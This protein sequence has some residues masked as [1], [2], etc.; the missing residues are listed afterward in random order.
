M[1]SSGSVYS[2]TLQTITNTKLEELSKKRHEFEEKHHAL[3]SDI[4]HEEDALNRLARLVNGV[5]SCFGIK[6]TPL[7]TNDGGRLGRAIYGGTTNGPLETDLRNIDRFLEQARY[8]PSLS[9]NIVKQWN[10]CLLEHLRVQSLRFQYADLYGK[11]VTEWLST[12]RSKTTSSDQDV[13]MAESF[14]EVPGG[15]KLESRAEWER[16]VFEPALVDVEA[17]NVYLNDLFKTKDPEQKLRL[18]ALQALRSSVKEFEMRLAAT[19]QF[20]V[21]SLRWTI[22]GLL[23]SDLLTDEK[24]AVLRDFEKNNIILAEIADV[25]NMRMA[26]IDTWTWGTEVS[27]EQRRKLNGT[28]NIYMHEDLLQAIFLQYIGVK[29]SV[30]F[31]SALKEF[32]K[33]KA[34][35]KTIRT[36]IPKIDKKRRDYYLG[37]Q[38][39]SPCIQTQR[40]GTHRKNYF[41]FQLLDHENQQVEI[42]DGE[43]EAEFEDFIQGAEQAEGYEEEYGRPRKRTMQTARKSTGGKAPRMQVASKMARRSA[44]A[45][46]A[47]HRPGDEDSETDDE[48]E[49]DSRSKKPME[50]KQG[51][52]H[53][54]STEIAINAGLYGELTCVRSVF[55]Q[56]NPSLPHATILAALA[57]FGVSETWQAFFK[58]FLQAP[59]KFTDENSA[60]PRTRQRGTPGS[61]ALSDVFGELILFCLDYS[62]NQSTDGGFLH[63]LHDE[64]WFWSHDNEKVVSAWESTT[65]FAKVM[66]VS[67]NKAKTGTARIV[68]DIS[69]ASNLDTRLPKGQIR[70]GFLFLDPETGRFEID[71]EMVDSHIGE[72]RNQLQGKSKSIFDWISAWNTYAA[73]FFASNFGKAANCFGRAHVDEMLAT[74]RRIQESIFQGSSVA[75]FLK[76]LIRE[77]FGI[78]DVP[79]GFLLFPVELGGL[80][81]KNPFVSLLQIHE[82]V[83]KDPK[84]ML[85]EFKEAEQDAYRQAKTTFDK[86]QIEDIR[87]EVDDPDWKPAQG[88]DEFM[89]F[90]EFTRYRE[91]FA[92]DHLGA[93]LL[94]VYND[95]LERPREE[96]IDVSVKVK[97]AIDQLSGQSNLKGI[98]NN[99]HGM[100]PYWKWVA[101]L[102]GPEVVGRFGGLN[103]VDPRLLPIGMVSL[104]REKRVKWQE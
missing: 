76:S 89:S 35:W 93:N 60:D 79:D 70:W 7:K 27:V 98:T 77:R 58:K 43:E 69:K 85:D 13:D 8:D 25:L 32:R 46:G 9:S 62:I 59:L 91:E 31:K 84:H 49:N 87:Y 39:Y 33:T 30:F 22:T 37:H 83:C 74:H 24:R 63:R 12:E 16:S 26:G 61:H 40:R 44:P 34:A 3:L 57:F 51:L 50:V 21:H 1:S 15:K 56:W 92:A 28:Y 17:L 90:E 94:K 96:S 65:R 29:W 104:F 18:K 38:S 11:L 36:D 6:T 102:Y 103:V 14:E 41:L 23:G 78:E 95:L 97:Q 100:E 68:E 80:D 55:D 66:G 81:L 71:R 54:L 53:L 86:G 42:P 47:V 5:K 82:S 19:G 48:N 75:E 73:T 67:L 4:Q 99:W 88:A 20:S 101:Q 72:L 2:A 45:T 64:V 10:D 52:L